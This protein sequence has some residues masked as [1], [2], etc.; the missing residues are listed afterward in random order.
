MGSFKEV[1]RLLN[2]VSL[3]AKEFVK[4]SEAVE[5]AKNGDLPKLIKKAIVSATDLSG[6][7]KGE[8]RRLSN[9]SSSNSDSVVHF[10][11]DAAVD[12]SSS[13]EEAVP[14][15]F[16]EQ[17]LQQ[18]QTSSSDANNDTNGNKGEAIASSSTTTTTSSAAA[19]NLDVRG[20][21]GSVREGEHQ[22]LVDKENTQVAFKR[23]KP[24]E[25]RVPSTP[26]SRA[27]GSVLFSASIR[28]TF[29]ID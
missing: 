1:G 10:A 25:R 16:Q 24:R 9:P 11:T 7:T 13:S 21:I 19:E 20:E 12:S 18:P 23:R 8:V 3:I 4:R 14:V 26:F 27:L 17:H 28:P 15:D 5:A 6:L 22:N 29:I 2:G